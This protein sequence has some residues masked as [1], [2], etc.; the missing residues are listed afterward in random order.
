MSAELDE[1]QCQRLFNQLLDVG[2]SEQEGWP[3]SCSFLEENAARDW[4]ESS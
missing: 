3:L 1:H 2:E 4:N